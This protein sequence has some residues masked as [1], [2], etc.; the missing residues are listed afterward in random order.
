MRGLEEFCEVLRSFRVSSYCAMESEIRKQLEFV[1]P[2]HAMRRHPSLPLH[3]Q[4]PI[5]A[6]GGEEWRGVLAASDSAAAAIFE[7][8]SAHARRR[9]VC[10][11]CKRNEEKPQMGETDRAKGRNLFFSWK[12]KRE[13]MSVSLATLST[14]HIT[15]LNI[16]THRMKEITHI[17]VGISFYYRVSQSSLDK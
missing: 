5:N 17:I 1:N 9:E 11:K 8:C 14:S 13:R 15:S 6:A 16:R 12:K 2:A 7:L 3:R 10:T 4:P